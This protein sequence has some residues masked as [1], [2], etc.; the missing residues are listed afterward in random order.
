MSL[1]KKLQLLGEGILVWGWVDK[2]YKD[3]KQGKESECKTARQAAEIT[4]C[5]RLKTVLAAGVTKDGAVM[6]HR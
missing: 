3:W 6:D 4:K 2:A 5:I 1:A